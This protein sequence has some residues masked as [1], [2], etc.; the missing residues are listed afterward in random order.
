VKVVIALSSLGDARHA[1]VAAIFEIAATR[2]A[3]SK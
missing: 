1:S 2:E 3:F